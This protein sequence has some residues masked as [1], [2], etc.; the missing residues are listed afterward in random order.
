MGKNIERVRS[1]HGA[2]AATLHVCTYILTFAIDVYK[3]IFILPITFITL[4]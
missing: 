2:T 4:R 3:L 1:K